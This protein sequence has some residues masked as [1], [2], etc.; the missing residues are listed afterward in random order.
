ML[1]P[2]RLKKGDK[3]AIV[4]LSRGL[5]GM[6]FCK[7]IDEKYYEEYKEVYKKV[8]SDLEKPILYNVNFGHSVPRHL[9]P[10]DAE[11]TIDYDNK[12]IFINTEILK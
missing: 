3:I 4:S 12:R 6:T 9:L 7:P 2:Q 5:L 8:F 10:Y 1:K 11:A